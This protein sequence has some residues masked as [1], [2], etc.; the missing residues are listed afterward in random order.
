MKWLRPLFRRS[1]VEREMDAELRFHFDQLV[2]SLMAAG[3]TRPQ[4]LRRAR[5][6]FGGIEQVKD[7]AREARM[8]AHAERIARGLRMAWRS[9][10]RSPGFTAVAVATLALGIGA[11]TLIFSALDQAILRNLPVRDPGRLV[12]F[13]SLGTNPGMDRN[14]GRKMSFSY[15]KYL[16]FRDRADVFEGV[17][18]RYTTDGS[19]MYNG[20][21]EMIN[22]E[23]VTGNY[24]DVLGVKAA[25]GRLLA[26]DDERQPMHDAVAVLSYSYWQR[27]FGGERAMVGQKVAINGMAMTVIGVSAKGFH[28]LDR[29]QSEDVRVPMTM[30]SL[31]TPTWPAGRNRR[32][33]AWLNIIARMKPGLSREQAEA[34]ANVLY[35]QILE[36][37]AKNLPKGAED[38]R[39]EFLKR[40][41]DLLP[42]GGGISSTDNTR[43]FLIEL[44]A[45]AGIVLTAVDQQLPPDRKPLLPPK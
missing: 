4:A 25:A 37:E 15:P 19:L 41:L 43:P 44:S 16:D 45:M 5:M 7:E 13:R 33:W 21:T 17:A 28:G 34:G 11:N 38:L 20:A 31:F 2:E 22:V 18:A 42:A 29:G 9:L 35:H 39:D 6:E 12:V 14:S 23:L 8:A 10:A 3:W 30:K 1:A 32:F 40:H 26:P 24:F 36:D 27:R